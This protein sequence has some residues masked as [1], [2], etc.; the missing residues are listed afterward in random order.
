MPR[1]KKYA[2]KKKEYSGVYAGL[3]RKKIAKLCGKPQPTVT[4][5]FH[6][7]LAKHGLEKG[8]KCKIT[9]DQLG[10]FIWLFRDKVHLDSIPDPD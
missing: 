10:E 3:T 4:R 9:E 8:K 6:E 7:Y 1:K 5:K 2:R